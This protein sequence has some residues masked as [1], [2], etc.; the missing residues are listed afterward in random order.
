MLVVEG[1]LEE[2]NGLASQT[3]CLLISAALLHLI[4]L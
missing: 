4:L 3:A 1:I 2:Q